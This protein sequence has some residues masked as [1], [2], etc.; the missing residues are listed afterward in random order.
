MLEIKRPSPVQE[1][2]IKAEV[3]LED[4]TAVTG[5]VAAL[6]KRDIWARGPS[7]VVP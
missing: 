3:S 2:L 1:V 5:V 7:G 4:S 6:T